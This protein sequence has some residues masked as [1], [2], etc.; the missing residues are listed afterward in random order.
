MRASYLILSPNDT[1]ELF[2]KDNLG[3][4]ADM[5]STQVFRPETIS[6]Q[7]ER[8]AWMMTGCALLVELVLFWRSGTLLGWLSLLM[9]L[10]LL[11]AVF[12]SLSNW[13][14]RKTMLVLEP[15]GVAFRNGLRSVQLT[16]DQIEKVR[17]IADRW[18]SRVLVSGAE[19][20]F[21][22]RMLSQ[23]ELR[24]KVGG[25]MGFSEGEAILKEILHSSGLSLAENNDQGQ[26]YARP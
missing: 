13:V 14:D 24:G 3:I 15:D 12:I 19:A 17:V 1:L 9:V 18:G 22:F 10:L 16:W 4:I 23:V 25:Q 2:K 20:N 5:Q 6:R 8:N 21:N 11:S 26:Y 7:G